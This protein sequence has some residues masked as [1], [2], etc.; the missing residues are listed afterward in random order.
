MKIERTQ[1]VFQFAMLVLVCVGLYALTA[2]GGSLEPTSAPA[3]TMHT[4][5][6]IYNLNSSLSHPIGFIGAN[7]GA[8]EIFMQVDGMSGESDDDTH[9]NW[10]EVSW[11]D[12]VVD[13]TSYNAGGGS[14][15][16]SCP[17]ISLKVVK[18]VDKA[19]PQ[20]LLKCCTGQS[21][22][23]VN[24]D[25]CQAGGNKIRFFRVE[26]ND[27][28]ISS[29]QP[30]MGVGSS[31]YYRLEVVTMTF[32]QVIWKYTEMDQYGQPAGTIETG[33]NVEGCQ[34]L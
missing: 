18:S 25:F 17:K 19:T 5:E 1:K 24:I 26:L 33:W 23:N 28:R 8:F 27:V 22:A 3:P 2:G 34:Q 13:H 12:S 31:G 14:Q 30:I 32:E 16:A 6:D 7:A 9:P 4:L 11:F 29:V 10:I 15:S 20:L 21:I